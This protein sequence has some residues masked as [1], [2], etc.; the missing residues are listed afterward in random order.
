MINVAATLQHLA[1]SSWLAFE[2]ADGDG[3]PLTEDLFALLA[4]QA[5]RRAAEEAQGASKRR[6]R[7]PARR[8]PARSRH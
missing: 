6:R 3:P 2:Q 4:V 7:Q 1:A 8:R 5:Y